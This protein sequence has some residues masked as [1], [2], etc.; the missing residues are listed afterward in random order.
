[1]NCMKLRDFVRKQCE[2]NEGCE[3]CK[4][5]GIS[6]AICVFGDA[7]TEAINKTIAAAMLGELSQTS[8]NTQRN[9]MGGV[10]G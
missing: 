7:T 2:S 8:T 6:A 1:M 9:G 4:V 5:N 10:A 3:K